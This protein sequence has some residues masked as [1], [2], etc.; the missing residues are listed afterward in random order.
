M[1]HTHHSHEID[2][3]GFAYEAI[4]V[5][6]AVKT[7]T[8]ATYNPATS[9]EDSPRAKRAL[10]TVET[11]QIRYTYNGTTPT[12]S[13]GHLLSAGDVLSLNGYG[14]IKRF[15]AIRVTTDASIKVTYER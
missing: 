7:L 12:S 10:I 13:I 11:D 2:Y 9:N 8:E 1:N 3:N 14:N 5:S 4:T 6:S 15:K